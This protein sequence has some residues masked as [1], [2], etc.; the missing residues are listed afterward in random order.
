MS[1]SEATKKVISPERQL[2]LPEITSIESLSVQIETVRLNGQT[3]IGLVEKLLAMVTN[4]TAEVSQLKTDKAVLKQQMCELQDLLS[5]KPCYTYG[6]AG[7]SSAKPAAVSYK[8]AVACNQRQQAKSKIASKSSKTPV[9]S[10]QKPADANAVTDVHPT[11][12]CDSAGSTTSSGNPTDDGFTIVTKNKRGDVR[13]VNHISE[14]NK[15]GRKLRTPMYGAR[16]S[17]SLPVVSKRPKTKALFVSRFSAEVS[18]SDVENSLQEPLKLS[19][20]VCAK[21]KTRYNS[22]ASF[23]VSVTEDDFPLIHNTGVW[24]EGCLIAPFYG[25]LNP[26]QICN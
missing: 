10:N 22:Y 4:L 18:A 3:A 9:A 21:L 17:S 20:V 6:A 23:Y 8:D 15:T 2:N 12:K 26:D 7:T 5:A 11:A 19:L 16:K 14:N 25:R 1:A 24:P 13:V